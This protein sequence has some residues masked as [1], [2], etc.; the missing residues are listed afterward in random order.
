MPYIQARLS[1]NLDEKQK[2][3]LQLKLTEVV[4]REFSKP[5]TYVMTEIEDDCSLYMAGNKVDNGA[6]VSVSLLGSASK[7]RCN[8]VTQQLCN[9]LSAE[10]GADSSKVYVTFHPENLWGWNG[11]MF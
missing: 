11:M 9:I 3:D 6:Y 7:D 4:S 1:K 8:N 5:A 10:Y 2:E